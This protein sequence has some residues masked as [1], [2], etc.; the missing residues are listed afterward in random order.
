MN[1][2][3]RVVGWLSGCYV[4]L[5][6][7]NGWFLWDYLGVTP[8][9]APEI[10][11][12]YFGPPRREWFPCFGS[13]TICFTTH[14]NVYLTP[15]H[16]RFLRGKIERNDPPMY[17]SKLMLLHFGV[18]MGTEIITTRFHHLGKMS[19]CTNR[20]FYF[21]NSLLHFNLR[22]LSYIYNTLVS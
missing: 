5:E 22:S 1:L 13:S 8:K 15:S 2:S 7:C 9:S 3:L 16:P 6:L 21:E 20:N 12:H 18:P 14:I 10:C 19:A 17:L 11:H 4:R